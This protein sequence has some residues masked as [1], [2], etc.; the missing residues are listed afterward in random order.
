MIY[1]NLPSNESKG[2]DT[3]R[4]LEVEH[5]SK[6]VRENINREGK[7]QQTNQ[8]T[9]GRNDSDFMS[10]TDPQEVRMKKKQK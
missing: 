9:P 6:R 2:L 1:K 10:E 3:L 5:M 4:L 8:A 7:R